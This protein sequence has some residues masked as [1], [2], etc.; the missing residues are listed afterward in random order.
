MVTS[1]SPVALLRLDSPIGRIEVTGDGSSL[2][3]LSIARAG[4]LPHDHL[5]DRPDDILREAARQLADYFRGARQRFE[6][7]IDARGTAFQRAVWA[8]LD[9]LEWGEITSYG[10]LGQATGR[11]TAG[12]AVG[13]AVGANPVPIIVPCHRVLATGRRITGYS[14]GDGIPTKAWLLAHEGIE[15]AA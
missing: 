8:R 12:R 3:S 1:P 6:L 13:G 14:G 2:T 9:E 11:P 4:V 10:E 7:P 15:F 5:D